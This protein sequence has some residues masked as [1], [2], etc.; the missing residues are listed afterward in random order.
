MFATP[1]RCKAFCKSLKLQELLNDK[2]Y[3]ME[4]LPRE[5]ICTMVLAALG[6][7]EEG[8]RKARQV[9][10][11]QDALGPLITDGYVGVCCKTLQKVCIKVKECM[12]KPSNGSRMRD[13]TYDARVLPYFDQYIRNPEVCA[14][15]TLP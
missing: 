11:I 8:C 3:Q 6:G 9:F 5:T 14:N 15:I 4:R 10:V 12:L 7:Q 1:N 13:T 2:N